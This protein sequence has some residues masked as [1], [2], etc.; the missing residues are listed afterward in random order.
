MTIKFEHFLSKFP[1]VDLP[2]VLSEDSHHDFSNRTQKGSTVFDYF[3]NS[4]SVLEALKRKRFLT[5]VA[6]SDKQLLMAVSDAILALQ[7]G[8]KQLSLLRIKR[9]ETLSSI[10]L[11]IANLNKDKISQVGLL[12]RKEKQ[13]QSMRSALNQLRAS[14]D[15]LERSLNGL[16]DKQ[17]QKLTTFALVK[18][19]LTFPVKGDLIHG[20]GKRKHQEFSDFVFSNGIEIKAKDGS[21][22]NAVASGKVM[23]VRELPGYG[24]VMILDHGS[25]VYSLYAR[26]KNLKA[27]VGDEIEVG[28]KLAMVENQQNFYFELRK[29]G[30]A[31]D[32]VS[33]FAD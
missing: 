15:E 7:D 30:K 12:E 3:A 31:I 25:R 21:S 20:F 18:G 19:C 14:A 13:R 16:L 26:I 9:Q 22:V 8:L 27:E 6:K 1:K 11:L 17:S 10:T 4:K 29:L 23:L 33:F 2:V 32:P 28:E 5:E 24:M